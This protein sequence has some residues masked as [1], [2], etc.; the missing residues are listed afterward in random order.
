[1]GRINFLLPD[2]DSVGEQ[3]G[4][5]NLLINGFFHF[6]VE[7]CFIEGCFMFWMVLFITGIY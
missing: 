7:M 6:S 5:N 3:S 4:P 2:P 1:M